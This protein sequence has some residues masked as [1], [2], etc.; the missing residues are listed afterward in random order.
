MGFPR[1]EAQC[2]SGQALEGN[3]SSRRSGRLPCPDRYA[4]ACNVALRGRSTLPESSHSGLSPDAAGGTSSSRISQKD[5]PSL[6]TP[7]IAAPVW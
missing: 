2:K 5:G 6:R 4:L 7:R 3:V 1:S